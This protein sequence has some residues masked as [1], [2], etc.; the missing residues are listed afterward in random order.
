M[1]MAGDYD[2][3]IPTCSYNSDKTKLFYKQYTFKI[4]DIGTMMR[5]AIEEAQNLICALVGQPIIYLKIRDP[6][7]YKDDLTL[8]TNGML[9]LDLNPELGGGDSR[10]LRWTD[11]VDK[12]IHLC[13]SRD[14]NREDYSF[15][16]KSVREFEA[17]V[18]QLLKLLMGLCH[19]VVGMPVRGTEFTCIKIRNTWTALRGLFIHDSAVMLVTE[20]HKAQSRTG[21]PRLIVRFLPALVGQIIIAYVCDVEPFLSFLQQRV[22]LTAYDSSPYLIGSKSD[23]GSTEELSKALAQIT[24][25][26][27]GVEIIVQSWRYMAISLNRDVLFEGNPLDLD[28]NNESA[29]DAQAAH[30]GNI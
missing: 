28:L 29:S 5:K 22:G 19:M 1:K 10:V 9:F 30:S 18:V 27:L 26:H 21:K 24:M 2:N 12:L 15:D 4:E 16:Q 11:E 17:K 8:A 7:L 3:A 14:F 20:Y 6:S 23:P 13:K 25:D